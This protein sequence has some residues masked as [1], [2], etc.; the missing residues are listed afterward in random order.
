MFF[1][2]NEENINKTKELE[3]IALEQINQALAENPD[4]IACI[5]LE[6][7][8][9]EGGDNFF[10]NEFHKELRR[11]CDENEILYILDEVQTG[12]G[13]TGKMWLTKIMTSFQTSLLS[14]RKH[15]FVVF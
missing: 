7:I 5:I 9:A 14:E 4:E 13:L 15:K 11:I 2:L 1:P 6:T 10:R 8:Q 12:M 3:K